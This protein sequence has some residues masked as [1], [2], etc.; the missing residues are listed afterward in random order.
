MNSKVGLLQADERCQS[1]GGSVTVLHS[2]TT[3]GRIIVRLLGSLKHQPYKLSIFFHPHLLQPVVPDV[4]PQ[5]IVLANHAKEEEAEHDAE[6][7]EDNLAGVS[8]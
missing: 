8:V 5:L 2:K 7:N 4:L 3:E 1:S 6:A